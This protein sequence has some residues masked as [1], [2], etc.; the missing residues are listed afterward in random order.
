MS[1]FAGMALLADFCSSQALHIFDL[2]S[3]SDEV[4]HNHREE[5][6]AI[7]QGVL[8]AAAKFDVLDENTHRGQANEL[9]RLCCEADIVDLTEVS[10]IGIELCPVQELRVLQQDCYHSLQ[11][12]F[13]F[14]FD[15][16]TTRVQ[17]SVK[18]QS[19]INFEPGR[20][21]GLVFEYL[22]G[23][24]PTFQW[25]T[26]AKAILEE[27]EEW[28][29]KSGTVI[30]SCK[31]W[32]SKNKSLSQRADQALKRSE[33]LKRHAKPCFYR[34]PRYIENPITDKFVCLKICSLREL[35]RG[36]RLFR[37]QG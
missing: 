3:N 24:P 26:K 10:N 28:Y 34:V 25:R 16:A 2:W 4:D 8:K 27:C 17:K 5:Y 20:Q 32:Y 31:D 29:S 14:L 37:A 1:T 35:P 7:I 30:A 6:L 15:L 23:P 33:K 9:D 22:V 12:I 13:G 11:K 36:N 19:S 21:G 18:E